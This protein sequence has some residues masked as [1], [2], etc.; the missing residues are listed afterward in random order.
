MRPARPAGPGQFL[1]RGDDACRLLGTRKP[2]L[3]SLGVEPSGGLGARQ[4]V[5]VH[6]DALRQRDGLGAAGRRRRRRCRGHGRALPQPVEHLVDGRHDLADLEW[7]DEVGHRAQRV[8]LR[9]GLVGGE[10]RQEHEGNVGHV[11]QVLRDVEPG[12]AVHA[13]VQ[14]RQLG[15]VLSRKQDRLVAVVGVD[16]LVAGLG[17]SVRHRRQHQPVVV[18]DED[19]ALGVHAEV[20]CA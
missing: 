16:D 14:Q 20:S 1:E 18:D 2:L 17:Q 6:Q 19:P 12:L 15:M 11:A 9:P 3:G 13:D 5:A 10:G 7:L 4:R 8:D